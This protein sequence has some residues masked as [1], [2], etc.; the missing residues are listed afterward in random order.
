MTEWLND[1]SLAEI[2]LKDKTL[3]TATSDVVQIRQNPRSQREAMVAVQII[4]QLLSS[5]LFQNHAMSQCILFFG[6]KF[7]KEPN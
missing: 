4:H 3:K 2:E 1:S 6:I 7:S 5:L